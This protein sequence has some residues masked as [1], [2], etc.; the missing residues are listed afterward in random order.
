M[1][2]ETACFLI[3]LAFAVGMTISRRID[4]NAARARIEARP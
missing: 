3:F 1:R 2:F 4:E